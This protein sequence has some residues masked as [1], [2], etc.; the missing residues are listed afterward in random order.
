VNYCVDAQYHDLPTT[1]SHIR[2]VTSRFVAIARTFA[3]TRCPGPWGDI[4]TWHLFVALV[5]SILTQ[6]KAARVAEMLQ[7]FELATV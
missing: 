3:I 1:S 5:C 4:K 6:L 7:K 2:N